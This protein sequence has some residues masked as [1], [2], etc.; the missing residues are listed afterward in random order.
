MFDRVSF[1]PGPSGVLRCSPVQDSIGINWS[2]IARAIIQL[3]S[4]PIFTNMIV[5]SICI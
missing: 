1:L 3:P 4:F 5:T 2:Q